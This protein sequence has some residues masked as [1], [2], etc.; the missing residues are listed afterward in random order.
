MQIRITFQRVGRHGA[1]GSGM[2]APAP[3]DVDSVDPGIILDA[4]EKYIRKFM[5]SSSPG[6]F[7]DLGD[8]C[9]GTGW[10]QAGMAHT[11]GTFTLAPAPVAATT[12]AT[13]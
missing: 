1:S 6:V 7:F 13:R 5:G 9:T 11:A 10:I 12:E 3:L 4:I 2:P 8:G